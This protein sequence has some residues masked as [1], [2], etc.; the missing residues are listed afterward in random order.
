MQK[1][2]INL[3]QSAVE[4]EFWTISYQRAVFRL[5]DIK[6]L[7][8]LAHL[9]AHPGERFHSRDLV[10]IVEGANVGKSLN[11]GVADA[12]LTIAGHLDG[13][14]VRSDARARTEYRERIADLK[15]EL[16]SAE[17]ANDIGRVER[18]RE[19]LEFLTDE[20]ASALRFRGRTR[21]SSSHA[22][23]ARVMVAKNIRAAIEK[24]RRESAPLGRHLAST[25]RTG[26]FCSYEPDPDH[27]VTWQL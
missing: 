19:E 26:Y 22:E 21:Q 16:D 23:R 3:G 15:A 8:Y 4:G 20:L 14:P 1:L 6:G 5:K 18:L 11:T 25:I 10:T 13:A 27:P 17:Q 24:I 9:L 2:R 7:A 12:N